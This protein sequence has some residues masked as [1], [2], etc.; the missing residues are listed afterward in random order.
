MGPLPD[1]DKILSLGD[2]VVVEGVLFDERLRK[3]LP[4]LD[5]GHVKGCEPLERRVG[6]T[7]M[8]QAD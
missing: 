8:E 4:S 5:R 2:Q 7:L 3:I 6:Q 1:S